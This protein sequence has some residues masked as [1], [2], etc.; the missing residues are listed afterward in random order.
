MDCW[1]GP[2]CCDRSIE[3]TPRT[4]I[5]RIGFV[6]AG[7]VGKGLSLALSRAGY[8]ITGVASRSGPLSAQEVT[9][10]SDLVFLTVP[11]DAIQRVAAGIVWRRGMAAVHCSGAAELALLEAA[12]RQ[13]AA[14][15]A[16]HPL[17]MFADP[18]VAA[19]GL[20]RCAIAVEAQR[21]LESRL[22]RIVAALGARPLRVPP[23]GRAAY[24]AGAHHAAA[25]LCPSLAEA[26]EIWRRLGIAPADA[27]AALLPLARGALDAIER[28]GPA[29][30]MA[31][32]I[33]RGDIGTVT[34]HI[35]ALE[36]LDPALR[37]NYCA[38][39]LRAIPLALQAGGIDAMRA[40]ELTALL[41]AKRPL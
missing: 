1:S 28:S 35:A 37:E 18:E 40:Q 5:E 25:F 41:S 6:G 32:S 24:H 20:A 29:R 21:E 31:G 30:A 17:Q 36:T 9:D 34:R 26:V 10:R 11:D 39:A 27:I 19:S 8:A 15:G 7:R 22:L 3:S 16:F 23:G 38:M 33:A 12:A 4:V 14:V 13:G 2:R